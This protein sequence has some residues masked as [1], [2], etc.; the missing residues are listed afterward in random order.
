MGNPRTGDRKDKSS[1]PFREDCVARL[2]QLREPQLGL[3]TKLWQRKTA[4]ARG[5]AISAYLTAAGLRAEIKRLPIRRCSESSCGS[6]STRLISVNPAESSIF[7]SV[8]SS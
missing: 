4:N 8:S 6:T 1:R 5:G 2:L 3:N 7:L